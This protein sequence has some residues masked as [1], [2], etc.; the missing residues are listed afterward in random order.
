MP[1]VHAPAP[2]WIHLFDPFYPSK[3]SACQA[4]PVHSPLKS[5]SMNQQVKSSGEALRISNARVVH[6]DALA[7]DN[8]LLSAAHAGGRLAVRNQPKQ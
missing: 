6:L 2:G 5:V 3:A 1:L 8:E 4:Y 7:L